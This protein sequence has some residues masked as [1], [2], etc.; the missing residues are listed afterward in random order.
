MDIRTYMEKHGI[1]PGAQFKVSPQSLEMKA[2]A[3][4][5]LASDLLEDGGGDGFTTTGVGHREST[6]GDRL[7]DCIDLVR[8]PDQTATPGGQGAREAP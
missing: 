4:H 6:T 8:D 7:Y 1:K 2:D 3:F 5:R